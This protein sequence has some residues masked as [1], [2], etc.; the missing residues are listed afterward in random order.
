[1]KETLGS[2]NT[3]GT[4][5]DVWPLDSS[6]ALSLGATAT[7]SQGV[8]AFTKLKVNQDPTAVAGNCFSAN[9]AA[10]NNA[11]GGSATGFIQSYVRPIQPFAPNYEEDTSFQAALLKPIQH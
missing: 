11:G 7:F 1:V 4:Q 3:V 9:Q 6:F 8:V 2:N 10:G 5:N